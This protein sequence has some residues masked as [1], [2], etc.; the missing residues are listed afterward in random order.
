MT[1][2]IWT[3]NWHGKSS[4]AFTKYIFIVYGVHIDPC[5]QIGFF[6]YVRGCSIFSKRQELYEHTEFQAIASYVWA[7]H[8]GKNPECVIVPHLSWKTHS[9]VR[10]SVC[11]SVCNKN[12]NLT[13]ILWSINDRTLIFPS[14]SL[15]WYLTCMIL[16]TNPFYWYDVEILTW[17]FDLLRGQICCRAGTTIF[18]ICLF[19][20]HSTISNLPKGMGSALF[21]VSVKRPYHDY[22]VALASSA[23]FSTYFILTT[24]TMNECH[25]WNSRKCCTY[26]CL[27]VIYF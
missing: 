3:Q 5:Y 24:C 8:G 11:P 14:L 20:I 16:V 15:Y 22:L 4:T 19:G 1:T 10:L 27:K 21:V 12:F 25:P 17:K 6:P 13:H 7:F 26:L 9:S 23:A 18:R 2:N